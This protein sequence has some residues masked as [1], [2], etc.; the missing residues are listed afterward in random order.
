[1]AVAILDQMQM[2][3]QKIAPALAVAEQRAHLVSAC[4]STWRPFGVLRRPAPAASVRVPP[5][6]KVG[7]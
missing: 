6:G 5:G 1:M 4:G 3:D 2:L 7:G